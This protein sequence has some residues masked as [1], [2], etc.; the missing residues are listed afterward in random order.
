MYIL[1]IKPYPSPH[2]FLSGKC[3]TLDKV[4]ARAEDN[5]HGDIKLQWRYRLETD[6]YIA[7]GIHSMYFIYKEMGE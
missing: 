2:P 3:L 1:N 5:N 7:K 6:S 4:M